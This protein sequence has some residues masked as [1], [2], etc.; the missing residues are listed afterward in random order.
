M[1]DPL[2]VAFEIRRPW[3]QRSPLP[4]AGH[5]DVRWKI[6]LRHDHTPACANEPPHPEGPF[7]WW[8]PSSY[9]AFARLAGRDFYWPPVITVWHR[10]P[11]G[12]DALT[13]CM[14]RTQRPDGEWKYSRGWRFH[15]HH[16]KIQVHPTQQLRRRLLTRCEWCGGR[17]AKGD[18]VNYSLQW[19]RSK[20]HW[21]QGERGLYHRDCSSISTAHH[22]CVCADPL[23]EHDGWGKCA[24][25][26]KF[27]AH[28]ITPEQ[29]ARVRE[30]AAIPEGTRR[31]VAVLD[32]ES[33]FDVEVD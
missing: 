16:W 2:V 31:A 15:A 6:R 33:D 11:G 14:K 12:R 18:R 26:G 4:A 30:L 29:L 13:V 17:D 9:S 32:G 3:P 22:E 20:G 21:W 23:L 1:H 27:R 7:P 19:H 24:L 28:G 8:K 5:R 25:C 10:E